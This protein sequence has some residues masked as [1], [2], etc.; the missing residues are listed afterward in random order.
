MLIIGNRL[1]SDDTTIRLATG[2]SFVEHPGLCVNC[3][4]MK[5]RP[6]VFHILKLEIGNSLA[7]DIWDAHAKRN[8]EDER[9]NYEALLELGFLAVIGI[10]VQRIVIH[11]K[12][13]EE[14]I[15]ILGDGATWPVLIDRSNFKLFKSSAELHLVTPHFFKSI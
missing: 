12:H 7:A 8:A 11:G 6:Q 14:R 13:A 10:D 1:N 15:V 4:A 2:E 3:V 5:G 9:T